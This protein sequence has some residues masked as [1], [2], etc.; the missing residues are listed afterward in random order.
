M[1]S[2][3]RVTQMASV[4]LQGYA[5]LGVEIFIAWHIHQAH[6][7][8]QSGDL[9]AANPRQRV[10]PENGC[11]LRSYNEATPIERWPMGP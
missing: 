6:R 3:E 2:R 5:S 7:W 1:T 4:S 10:L 8:R 11:A 9:C